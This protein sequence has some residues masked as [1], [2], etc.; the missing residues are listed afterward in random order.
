[1]VRP[2]I[3]I[4][5]VAVSVACVTSPLGRRQLAFFPE[6]EMASMGVAA[7]DKL[8]TETPQS[9]D[10]GKNRYVRCVAD[11]IT[12]EIEGAHAQT[13]WEVTLFEE[14][15]ANA[16]ALPGGKI[17]VHTGLLDVARGQDQ[18]ATVL[19][20][21]VAHVLANHSNERVSTAF[22]TQT[23]L[24]LVQ[25]IS[26]AASPTQQQLFGLLGVGAQVGILLPFSRTQE[27][28]ADLLGLDLMGR[29]GFDPRQSV[30]L[31]ENMARAGGGQ[32]PEF[33]STHPSHDTRIQDLEARIPSVMQLRSAARARGKVPSCS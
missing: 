5:V 6:A 17:G 9:K 25:S 12:A 15:S 13:R 14:S 31:W 26:G 20:H 3:C 23:G 30:D 18:L 21:E 28:E 16:F 7:Y 10:A 29:A 1:M 27:S 4:A 19:G 24:D 33:L 8:K 2:L 11:A 22:A 32:P